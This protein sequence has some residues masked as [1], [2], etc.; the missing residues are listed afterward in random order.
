M[1]YDPHDR[2]LLKIG[3]HKRLVPF[4]V[5]MLEIDSNER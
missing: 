5:F 1:T 2:F 4:D 3:S